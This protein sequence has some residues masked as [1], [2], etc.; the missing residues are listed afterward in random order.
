MKHTPKPWKC[1]VVRGRENIPL[2]IEKMKAWLSATVDR[3]IQHGDS[4]EDLY[5][6]LS[7]DDPQDPIY[8]AITG[9][10]PTSKANAC[11]IAAGPDL[12]EACVEYVRKADY[13]ATNSRPLYAQMKAAIAKAEVTA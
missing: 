7:S 11:L 2:T 6:V 9:N 5:V 8:T 10:G 4:V 13:F 12:L 1:A 3:T